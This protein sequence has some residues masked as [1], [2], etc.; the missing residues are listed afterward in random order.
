[1]FNVFVLS[2]CKGKPYLVEVEFLNSTNHQTVAQAI[3][4]T[5]QKYG[6]A[7]EDVSDNAAYCLKAFCDILKPLFPNAV[8]IC[9]LPHILNLVGEQFHVSKHLAK[10]TEFTSMT[11]LHSRRKEPVRGDISCTWQL[12]GNHPPLLQKLWGQD[13]R[14]GMRQLHTAEKDFP[15]I[16]N[17]EHQ[18][19]SPLNVWLASCKMTFQNC[20]Y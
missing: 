7:F 11:N 19:L 6:S 9:C 2:V 20:R 12:V 13:G 16:W 14:A 18:V 10:L 15:C 1:M 3:I 17:R 8:H 5:V 4:K